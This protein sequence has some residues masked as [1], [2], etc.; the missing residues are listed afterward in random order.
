MS[1]KMKSLA[2]V[3]KAKDGIYSFKVSVEATLAEDESEEFESCESESNMEESED[4][5]DNDIVDIE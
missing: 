2:K 3:F 4:N 5:K 1:V